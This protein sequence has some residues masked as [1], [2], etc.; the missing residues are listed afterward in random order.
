MAEDQPVP[1][2]RGRGRPPGKTQDAFVG[3]KVPEEL[4]VRIRGRA[5]TDGVNV[6]DVVRAALEAYLVG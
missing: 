1:V 6:S 4:V 2:K 5:E 3:A